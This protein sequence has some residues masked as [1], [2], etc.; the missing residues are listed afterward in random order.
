MKPNIEP[1]EP[2]YVSIC[3]RCFREVSNRAYY[4]GRQ[5]SAHFRGSCSPSSSPYF[6]R[7]EDVE[8][9]QEY[10]EKWVKAYRV[11]LLGSS[12]PAFAFRIFRDKPLETAGQ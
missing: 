1:H 5:G 8:T 7:G 11:T 10:A 3:P 9:Y 2:G 4:A 6:V 12:A